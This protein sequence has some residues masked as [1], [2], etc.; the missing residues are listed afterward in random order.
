MIITIDRSN[1]HDYASELDDAYRLRHRIFVED[2]GWEALRRP[3]RRE[4]D[5]F[6]D[7]H[8]VEMLLFDGG[9]L[10]GYQRLL[11]TTRPYLLTEIYPQLCDGEP[12]AGD[13]IYEWTR[14]AVDKPYRGDGTGLGKVGAELVLSY[15]EWGLANGVRA[16]VV[17]LP[18]IQMLKFAQCHF[19]AHPLV[20]DHCHGSGRV[21]GVLCN[22]RNTGLGW[23]EMDRGMLGRVSQYLGAPCHAD[24]LLDLANRPICE[25]AVA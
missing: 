21:R 13:H 12:P 15:V 20:V 4:R 3:D 23:L 2:A 25:E 1:R 22:R 17:E 10:I 18:P 24:V 5:R 7:E 8:A 19:M 14:F 9:R 16:V 11:P 6:D